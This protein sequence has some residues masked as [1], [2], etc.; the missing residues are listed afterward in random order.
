MLPKEIKRKLIDA[1]LLILM[2]ALGVLGQ[3]LLTRGRPF[4]GILLYIPAMACLICLNLRIKPFEPKFFTERISITLEIILVLL[5][6]L[7][8]FFFK[9][10]SV[11]PENLGMSIEEMVKSYDALKI[12]EGLPYKPNFGSIESH[13]VYVLAF[14]MK[15]FGVN[16]Y[17]LRAASKVLG[18]LTVLFTYLCLRFLFDARGAFAGSLLMGISLWATSET[19]NA[20]RQHTVATYAAL[21]FGLL[22]LGIRRSWLL[23]FLFSGAIFLLGYNSYPAY[24][25]IPGAIII[26]LIFQVAFNLKFIVEHKWRLLAF[27]LS[28]TLI[29][30]FVLLPY[31]SFYFPGNLK[32]RLV[33]EGVW[34][35]PLGVIGKRAAKILTSFNYRFYPTVELYVRHNK[36]ILN[37]LTAVAYIFGFVLMLLHFRR[38]E[39]NLL[40]AWFIAAMAPGLMFDCSIRRYMGLMPLAFILV[41]SFLVFLHRVLFYLIDLI[42]EGTWWLVIAA[43]IAVVSW[44]NYHELF[45]DDYSWGTVIT[46]R[47]EIYDMSRFISDNFDKYC[48]MPIVGSDYVCQ[49]VFYTYPRTKSTTYFAA[50]PSEFYV[51]TPSFRRYIPII[52]KLD[53]DAMLVL[54]KDEAQQWM[55]DMLRFYYPGCQINSHDYT[56]PNENKGFYF[57]RIPKEEIFAIQGF[58]GHLEDDKGNR[59]S[60][61]KLINTENAASALEVEFKKDHLL[62]AESFLYIPRAGSYLFDA[63]EKEHLELIIEGKRVLYYFKGSLAER[64]AIRLDEGLHKVSLRCRLYKYRYLPQIM[65]SYGS[66]EWQAI[67]LQRFI[68]K[69]YGAN[70]DS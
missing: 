9:F 27:T 67:P 34:G 47:E 19:I 69:K 60:G 63:T 39:F 51:R 42:G 29:L 65:T 32:E 62:V 57:I 43:L 12:I 28:A 26:F 50:D 45:P 8:T 6:L 17:V 54:F 40:I 25:T 68:I 2:L 36:P 31:K 61:T 33:H 46:R 56:K 59:I 20:W 15:H 7:A 70:Q 21:A 49:L 30:V 24:R 14:F 48:F 1:G 23:P 4:F 22:I 66:D 41:G 11:P 18:I 16:L 35:D 53:K 37:S 10:S 58:T 55:F 38:W 44:Q 5:V 64:G 13:F 3:H 52:K